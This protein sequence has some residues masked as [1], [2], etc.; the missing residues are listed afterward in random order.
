[1]TAERV[2][3]SAETEFGVEEPIDIEEIHLEDLS[4]V[5]DVETDDGTVTACTLDLEEL[6]HVMTLYSSTEKQRY[7]WRR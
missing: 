2:K 7:Q 5:L 4:F 3:L 1:M 6:I